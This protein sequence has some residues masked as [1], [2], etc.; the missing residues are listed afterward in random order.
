MT[1]EVDALGDRCLVR[2]AGGLQADPPGRQRQQS[3]EGSQQRRLA[4]PV[5]SRQFQR[6]ARLQSEAHPFEHAAATADDRHAVDDKG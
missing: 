5:G 6:L 2:A 4:R 3:R 1:D